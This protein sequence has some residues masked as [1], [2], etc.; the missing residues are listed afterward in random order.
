L[1]FSSGAIQE[2]AY[3]D[4]KGTLFFRPICPIDDGSS[5]RYQHMVLEDLTSPD[6][7]LTLATTDKEYAGVPGPIPENRTRKLHNAWWGYAEYT[8]DNDHFWRRVITRGVRN[9]LRHLVQR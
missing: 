6:F 7:W 2:A 9:I 8:L 4:R 5:A 3:F 1:P